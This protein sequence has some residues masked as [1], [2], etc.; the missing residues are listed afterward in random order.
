MTF[1]ENISIIP[2]MIRKTGLTA[3]YRREASRLKRLLTDGIVIEG[4]LAEVRAG[5]AVHYQLTRKV[6]GRTRTDYVPLAMKAEVADW[7][8]RWKEAKALLKALSDCSRAIL[9]SSAEAKARTGGRGRSRSGAA[10]RPGSRTR[11]RRSAT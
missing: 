5:S 2:Y 6:K 11:A 4:T 9:R 3:A 10:P 7:T 8:R 1:D